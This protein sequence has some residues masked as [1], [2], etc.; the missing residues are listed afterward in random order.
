MKF[1]ISIDE[2]RDSISVVTRA[3]TNRS[4]VQILE[5]ILFE[6]KDNKLTLRASDNIITITD[7]IAVTVEEDGSC[8]VPGKLINDLVRRLPSGI[9]RI[10]VSD[11]MQMRINAGR[12]RTT[13]SCKSA[14]L[15]PDIPDV[16]TTNEI[17]L[18]Q[19]LIKAMIEKTSFAVSSDPNRPVLQ[20]GFF[21]AKDNMLNFVTVDGF[22]MG[23]IKNK[24]NYEGS[25]IAAIIPGK[26]MDEIAKLMAVEE[27]VP[28]ASF[29]FGEKQ[30]MLKI[31]TTTLYSVLINGEYI[32]YN[33]IIPRSSATDIVVKK[34]ELADCI[35][36]AGL[37]AQQNKNKLVVFSITDE[38]VRITST[39][40]SG[41][42]EETCEI[43]EKTGNDL[44][45]AFNV[46]YL[47]NI[48]RVIESENIHLKLNTPVSPCVI[49]SGDKEEA[50]E[51]L[52]L[53][54][55]VRISA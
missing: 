53:V 4:T 38:G 43:S 50:E 54:L 44:V 45:I 27:N 17:L 16:D 6:A 46:M 48:M 40:E 36:R 22:R 3:L 23:Y 30:M 42:A 51:Y 8:V 18:P 2:L 49:V 13:I 31:G 21:E 12:S 55:P 10:S 37:M 25:R 1:S 19:N 32:D 5:G 24:I 39:S 9:G 20:G 11:S 47:T 28:P 29:S 14:D 33:A 41:D 35:E 34:E 15:Y 26:T 7:E 52:Y